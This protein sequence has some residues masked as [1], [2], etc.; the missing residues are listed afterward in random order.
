[1]KALQ[2]FLI[3]MGVIAVLAIMAVVVGYVMALL[4]PDIRSNMRP[5]VLSS[6]AVDSLNSKVDAFKKEAVGANNSKTQK[7]IELKVTEEE[8]NSLIVMTLAE[9]TLPAREMLVNLNDG[10]L[11]TYNAWN[12]TG[13][14]AKTAIMGSFDVQDGK[15]KFLVRDFFLGKLPV[16]AAMDKGVQ[17]GA[18]I[19]IKLNAPFQELKL[20]WKE[21]TISEGQLRL[22]ASTRGPNQ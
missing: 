2:G 10:Y 8:I 6:E 12:F 18:N 20:D 4:T 5:V 19:L 1:M 3:I 15:P 11:L 7:N 16:P 22:L 21:V 9:G 13:F 14:P 17:D